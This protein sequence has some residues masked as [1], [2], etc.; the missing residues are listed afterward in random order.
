MST[1]LEPEQSE[2]ETPVQVPRKHDLFFSCADW[3]SFRE[4][5]TM[6][7]SNIVDFTE[8]FVMS[9]PVSPAFINKRLSKLSSKT[10]QPKLL[11]HLETEVSSFDIDQCLNKVSRTEYKQ[12]SEKLVSSQTSPKYRKPLQLDSI[13]TSSCETAT[14]SV[15]PA[16]FVDLCLS[17]LGNYEARPTLFG[18]PAYKKQK[19]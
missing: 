11:S 4:L 17:P 9:S 2:T 7:E 6:K 10:E 15:D 14:E 1:G 12:R 8:D 16:A 3:E 13:T 18:E 19:I 5:E